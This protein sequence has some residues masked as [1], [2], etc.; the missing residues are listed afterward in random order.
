MRNALAAALLTVLAVTFVHPAQ[1]QE[2]RD[3]GLK[4]MN[5]RVAQM[6]LTRAARLGTSA[7]SDTFFVGHTTTAP[8]SQ[9]WHVG[10]GPYRPGVGGKYDGMWDFDTYDAGTIDSMQGWVPTNT[11]NTRS[12]GTISDDQRPWQCLDW[13]N[14][15]NA[16]PVQGRTPGV[17][18]A[19]HVDN[20]LYLPPQQAGK[21]ANSWARARRHCVGVVRSARRW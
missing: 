2:P 21:V 20:G 14:R 18:S 17:V 11:P 16:G 9:P 15:L 1:A 6:Q 4:L 12:S 3:E 8:F 5:A 19:W 10:V 7:N 13:G